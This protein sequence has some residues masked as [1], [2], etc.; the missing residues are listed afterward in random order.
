MQNM[1]KGPSSCNF[2]R[3]PVAFFHFWCPIIH[4]STQFSDTL[5][6]RSSDQ[7]SHP[8]NTTCKII[9]SYILIF[10]L[11]DNTPNYKVMQCCRTVLAAHALSFDSESVSSVWMQ[12]ASFCTLKMQS[13]EEV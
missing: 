9:I 13:T 8:Y 10:T 11:F 12:L 4:L 6:P 3:P 5:D 2:L 1:C 7:V